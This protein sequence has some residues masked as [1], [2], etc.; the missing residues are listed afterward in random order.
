MTAPTTADNS[1]FSLPDAL[2]VLA[3]TPATLDALLRPL[4]P[5]SWQARES[6]GA[7]TPLDVLAHLCWCEIDDWM[8]RANRILQDGESRAFEPFDREGG[9][10]RYA[11]WS[12][13]QLLAEFAAR[14]RESLESLRAHDLQPADLA[15]RGRHPDL[16]AVTLGQLL[17]TWATHDLGH[18]AQ[19]A[20]TL[21]RANGPHVGPWKKYFSL[22][23]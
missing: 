9:V 15:R 5:R 13:E 21:V 12:G 20:R 8:P 22:L 2:G 6:P 17:A 23:Q 19:I 3:H 1:T 18:L 11:G 7:W 14:R 4:P 16:G 10:A